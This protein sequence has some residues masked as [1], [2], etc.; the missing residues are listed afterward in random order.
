[1]ESLGILVE[2]NLIAKKQSS[3]FHPKKND[4]IL[5]IGCN[6]GSFVQ[7]LRGY[8]SQVF[9]CDI[10]QDSISTSNIDG[11]EV[12]DAENLS[13]KDQSFHKLVSLHTVEHIPHTKTFLEE[14]SHVLKPNGLC[15]LIYP[16]E[17][18]RGSNNFLQAWK[19]YGNP[20]VS[21]K[22]HIHRFTPSKIDK[23]TNMKTVKKGIFFA[24]YPTYFTVLCKA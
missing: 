22:L 2:K 12:M 14:A 4:K 20:T 16:F 15:V 7:E 19:L 17:I 18:F 6:N 10:N 3:F 9:G 11:L 23:S 24:P 13:Y 5:E 21:K 1:M 8:A